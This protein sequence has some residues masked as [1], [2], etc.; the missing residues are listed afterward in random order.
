MP[1]EA[2]QAEALLGDLGITHLLTLSP[3]EQPLLPPSVKHC[4]INMPIAVPWV[5]PSDALLVALPEGCDFIREALSDKSA[6]VLVY[7]EVESKACAVVCAYRKSSLFYS[8]LQFS[9]PA[10]F[11]SH[12]FPQNITNGSLLPP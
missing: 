10:A 12:V 5:G 9:P 6:Q 4:H 7:S 3:A 11:C 1:T 8:A 2:D